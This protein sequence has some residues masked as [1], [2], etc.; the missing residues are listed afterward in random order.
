LSTESLPTSTGIRSGITFAEYA[1]GHV[2]RLLG[3]KLVVDV[4]DAAVLQYQS[5]RLKESAA[6]KSINEEV[7]F[8]ARRPDKITLKQVRKALGE[9]TFRM[10]RNEP[11]PKCLVGQNV[12]GVLEQVYA[13]AE[14]AVMNSLDKWTVADMLSGVRKA[15]GAV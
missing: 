13:D 15:A 5:D 10:H 11:N 4:D 9:A 6:P 14:E 8:L 1:I 7:R 12:R 3:D 2:I